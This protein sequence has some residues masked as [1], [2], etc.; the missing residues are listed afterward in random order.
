MP[1]IIFGFFLSRQG[2]TLMKNLGRVVSRTD[3][4]QEEIAK[5]KLVA[6]DITL[7]DRMAK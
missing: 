3:I 4:A 7:A 2:Q 6:E 5:S 1:F